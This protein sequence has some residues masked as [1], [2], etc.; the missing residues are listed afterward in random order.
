M[1]DSTL[2]QPDR[3]YTRREDAEGRSPA[4]RLMVVEP[5]RDA[6]D[7]PRGRT[8]LLR[9][10]LHD[11]ARPLRF[12]LVGSICG[13]VQLALLALFLRGG[14]PVVPANVVAFLLSA[15]LNFVLSTLFIWHDR[16]AGGGMTRGLI[17]RWLGFHG[18]I[19]GTAVLNQAVFVLALL[20][21][22]D[23]AASALG[24]GVAAVANFLLQDRLVF[25]R[26]A[27]MRDGEGS[28]THLISPPIGVRPAQIAAPVDDV[29]WSTP[30][31]Q[32][33]D[34]I[35]MSQ[36]RPVAIHHPIVARVDV[37]IPVYNEERVLVKS[38]STLHA[39]LTENLR[40][41]WRIVIADN[42]STDSTPAVA[43][44]LQQRLDRIHVLHLDQKGRG[45]AL[46]TAWLASDA[47]VL[48]YMDVDLSTDL[49]AY[50]ALVDAL[51]CGGFDLATGRRLGAGARVEGRR[52]LR[53]V[54]SRGY[55]LL[56]R[57][58][59][60]PHFTDAQCGFKAITRYAA[61][62]LLPQVE[63]N[64]WFFDTELLLLADRHGYR[65]TQIA[66]HW[67]DDPDSRVNVFGTAME[68]LKGLWRLK[69]GAIGRAASP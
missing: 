26:T 11:R 12:V 67:V 16:R 47:D 69:R 54:T 40:H 64:A 4:S 3:E 41:D 55:N 23:L 53:E 13:A 22:P 27:A 6:P 20:V 21:A 8:R 36:H 35:A 56:I 46:R 37:V 68:D 44:A 57:L 32:R 63:D 38:I 51:V 2:T 7:L 58:L 31:L 66:V 19:A 52:P 25:R 33:E 48:S 10:L 43:R 30:V 59:F 17:R 60:R 18:S 49:S 42:A 14:A 34:G 24:I 65:I 28:G 50:P 5:Q 61:Q 62:Y 29:G 1:I 9:G 15:Q 39:F 45:R